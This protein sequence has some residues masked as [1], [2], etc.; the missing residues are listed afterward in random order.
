MANLPVPPE[1][2]YPGVLN[3]RGFDTHG[4]ANFQMQALSGGIGSRRDCPLLSE[5][6]GPSTMGW[7]WDGPST[8]LREGME[9]KACEVSAEFSC[10]EEVAEEASIGMN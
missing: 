9:E 1:I 10:E 8:M 7:Q 6:D 3:L 4:V 5:E 2:W